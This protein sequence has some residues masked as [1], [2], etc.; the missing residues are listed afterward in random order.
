[1]RLSNCDIRPPAT[2]AEIASALG[3]ISPRPGDRMESKA[4]NPLSMAWPR[5]SVLL[6]ESVIEAIEMNRHLNRRIQDLR[7]GLGLF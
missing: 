5:A 7:L 1:M 6:I 2:W 3:G 4:A